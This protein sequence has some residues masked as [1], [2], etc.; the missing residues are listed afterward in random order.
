MSVLEAEAQIANLSLQRAKNF[1]DCV[2]NDKWREEAA[3]KL[4]QTQEETVKKALEDQKLL[5]NEH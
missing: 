5:D 2:N 1:Q 3:L 4:L